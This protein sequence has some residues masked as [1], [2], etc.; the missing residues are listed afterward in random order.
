M[1]ACV[2]ACVRACARSLSLSVLRQHAASANVCADVRDS[3]DD[4]AFFQARVDLGR[5]VLL[6]YTCLDRLA[7]SVSVLLCLLFD[8]VE[9]VSPT[10]KVAGGNIHQN[11]VSLLHDVDAV[12]DNSPTSLHPS[13][14]QPELR[15]VCRAKV[16]QRIL[17]A[18]CVG[19]GKYRKVHPDE[20]LLGDTAR[21]ACAVGP[22]SWS[23]DL[24]QLHPGEF[25]SGKVSE[26]G[27]AGR[28]C[29]GS[30]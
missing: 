30:R 4:V 7:G 26:E 13:Y 2:R 29:A 28:D 24:D 10:E 11:S 8:C 16:Q 6:S 17:R 15:S 3:D 1:R 14:L 5:D 19:A 22:C 21:P 20:L 23:R 9:N 27:P 25:V 12:G 18:G